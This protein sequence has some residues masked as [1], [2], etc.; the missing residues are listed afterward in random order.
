M[1]CV[2]KRIEKLPLKDCIIFYIILESFYLKKTLTEHCNELSLN[3]CKKNR[4]DG[5]HDV[6]S[7]IFI[8]EGIASVPWITEMIT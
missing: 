7:L 3:V 6:L 4:I 8:N 5:M 1:Y 2:Q